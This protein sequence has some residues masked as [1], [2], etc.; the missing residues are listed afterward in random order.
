V[1]GAPFRLGVLALLEGDVV[2]GVPDE[3][4]GEHQR[5]DGDDGAGDDEHVAYR[6]RRREQ[7]A[8][9][10]GDRD[11]VVA[12]GFERPVQRPSH[13]VGGL[14]AVRVQVRPA[15]IADE[16][17][18]AGE[19]DPRIRRGTRAGGEL[20]QPGDVVGLHVGLEPRR[21]IVATR[22]QRS[23]G[24]TAPPGPP[25]GSRVVCR[26]LRPSLDRP[27]IQTGGWLATSAKAAE[28]R[29]ASVSSRAREE[30]C[31]SHTRSNPR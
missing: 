2:G 3:E 13:V 5:G 22:R 27:F 12:G 25:D 17:R 14:L 23:A 30:A 7:P 21:V 26:R 1:S 18:V 11:A 29:E 15:R 8:E 28:Q 24:P 20:E 10:C 19:D 16:Q 6:E 31:P 4:D 9:G